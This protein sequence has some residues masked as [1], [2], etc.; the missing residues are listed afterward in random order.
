MER[1]EQQR[2]NKVQEEDKRKQCEGG[3]KLGNML[4]KQNLKLLSNVLGAI[5]VMTRTLLLLL[6]VVDSEEMDD[7][8]STY[9]SS[10]PPSTLLLQSSGYVTICRRRRRRQQQQQQPL[11]TL[12]MDILPCH[13]SRRVPTR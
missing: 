6:L 11:S 10:P 7:N 13:E 3:Q 12:G 9:S 1:N 8:A 2:K 5:K 4:S